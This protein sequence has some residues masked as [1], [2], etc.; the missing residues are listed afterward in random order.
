MIQGG[1]DWLTARSDHSQAVVLKIPEAIG[2][3]LDELHF[4]MEA[5]RNAIVLGLHQSLG[6]GVILTVERAKVRLVAGQQNMTPALDGGS[7][8]GAVFFGEFRGDLGRKE[9]TERR[10][11]LKL[12]QQSLKNAFARFNN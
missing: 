11:G 2:S 6:R 7:Q 12:F 4:A 3:P 8:Y 10:R 5:F 9:A 1:T